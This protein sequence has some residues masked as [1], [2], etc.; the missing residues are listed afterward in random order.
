M[1][2]L[3]NKAK[4]LHLEVLEKLSTL[5][6]AGLGLVAALAWNSLIQEIFKKIFGTQSTILAQFAYALLVTV[7]IVVLTL[8]IS[9]AVNKLKGEIKE[10]SDKQ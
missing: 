1:D 10:D 6:T 2:D 9:R 4:K 7:I 5:V 8:Q 3:K